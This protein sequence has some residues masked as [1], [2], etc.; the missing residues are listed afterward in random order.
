MVENLQDAVRVL[1]NTKERWLLILDN[2]DDPDIDYQIFLPS[3]EDGTVIIT[4]RMRDCQ[5]Y[6]TIGVVTVDSLTSQELTKLLLKASGI[7]QIPSSSSS[8]Q[9]EELISILGSHTLAIIQAGAF[10]AAGH[11][12]LDQ[13]VELF[14]RYHH[15]MLQYGS[16]QAMSRYRNIYATFEAATTALDKGKCGTDALCLLDILSTLYASPVP[17]QIFEDA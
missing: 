5:Q 10:I 6:S 14:Q 16:Q 15:R 4:S 1:A 7:H 9:A 3:G 8:R 2:A 12:R 17:I 11:F 13:Y